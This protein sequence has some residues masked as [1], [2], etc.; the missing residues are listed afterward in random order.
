LETGKN[1]SKLHEI[2]N[3]MKNIKYIIFF[4]TIIPFISLSQS[5]YFKLPA[6]VTESDY[7]SKTIIIKIKEIYR[8]QCNE[9]GVNIDKLSKAFNSIGAY[10]IIKKF[11]GKESPKTKLNRYGEKMEDLSL[12]YE[13]K[14]NTGFNIEK[15]INIMLASGV[16]EFAEPHYLAQLF[17]VPND[18]YADTANN[19]FSQYHLN[20]IKAY[21]AWDIQKSDTNI[22]I[23]ITDTG[24]DLFHPDLYN[25]IKKNYY[26]TINGIDDDADGFTDNFF[27][28]DMAENDSSPQWQVI[29]HGVFVSGLASGIADN[30]QG[31]AGVGFNA[32]F[33]PVKISD[34]SGVITMGYEGIV[35]AAE[36]GC[37][38]V[39][40]SWGGLG[41][42]QY[43]QT[44]VNYATNNCNA[45][46]IAAAG[47]SNN[48]ATYYPASYD[49]V[50]S[51]G[52]TNWYDHLWHDSTSA[53]GSSYGLH[54][55][56]CA[57]GQGIFSTWI[58]AG[59][60]GGQS[61]TSFA[62]PIVSG[63]AALVKSQFPSYS[64]IQ[65]GEQLK[66]TTDNIDTI[67]YNAP[68]VGMMGTGRLNI[69]K[70]L[71]LDNIPSI[72]MTSK[73][74]TDNNDELHTSFDTLRIVG[75]FKNYLAQSSNSLKV[76]LSSTS[77]YVSILN[78]STLLGMMNTFEEKMNSA[79]PF[80][81]KILPGVPVSTQI[82]F[83]LTF[84]DATVGYKA[85][86]SFSIVVNVDYIDI[87]TNKVA[88]TITSKG[89]IGYNLTTNFSQGVGF[90]YKNSSS[91]MTIG[92]LMLGTSTSQVSDN[93][94]G[95]VSN[96]FDNDFKTKTVVH[97][98]EPTEKS[99]FETLCVFDDS[100]APVST[101]LNVTVTHKT[102]TWSSA[103]D[104]KYIIMEYSIKN[105]GTQTLSNL[106]AG[107]FMDFDM[108]GEDIQKDKID[109]DATN[110]M[111]YTY[112][113]NS[114]PYAAIKLLSSGTV[115]HYAFD[116]DGASNGTSASINIENGFTSYE[117]Y[118][119]LK[120]NQSR[121]TTSQSGND[122]ADLIST[123][124]FVI[125]PGD[126]EVVAFALIAGD[127]LADIQSSAV[128]ADNYY[129]HYGIDEMFPDNPVAT[130]HVFP[131]PAV[132]ELNVS[133]D[134]QTSSSVEVSVVD[135][136]GRVILKKNLGKLM[137]GD[138]HQTIDITSVSSGTYS[139]LLSAGSYRRT[140]EITITK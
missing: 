115:H 15:A 123:G 65:I 82:D 9:K 140:G 103:P 33:L 87:D 12:I 125:T 112:S 86:Q 70:A 118:S 128:A 95:D 17:Y 7:M 52:A 2:Y 30:S 96:H 59:Y 107:L 106:Y 129:N 73:S 1:F 53:F 5:H 137:F 108:S 78:S 51:V 104:D 66:L 27:G 41:G 77:S 56:L 119:A 63:A 3:Y 133:F 74:I 80:L 120:I 37:S 25:N 72:V 40:C 83:K 130:L 116:K 10:N 24:V 14:Y 94:Y 114:S 13:L 90:T 8:N 54:V 111:G 35:Y 61:G 46:V 76:S 126:S 62:A 97:R 60:L 58:N 99:D 22:V 36:H 39:C 88:T 26:D 89:K 91:Y 31:G 28:W 19:S 84:E 75:T 68:W 93:V 98:V 45:L 101:R 124:P 117:K 85:Y 38:V 16:L 121:N 71:T 42:G 55:D 122:V 102:Y 131:N 29:G 127:H 79:D 20:L 11:P 49:N 113:L 44:I 34:A 23:G 64:A 109:Y 43:G 110:K 48:N 21:Q 105:N 18:P 132:N 136:N 138:H 100:L 32:K 135:I 92:G 67:P 69:Y 4:L 139:V 6:T 47:N 81:V 50:L 57:P 134:L